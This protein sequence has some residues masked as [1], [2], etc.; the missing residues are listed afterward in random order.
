MRHPPD[1]EPFDVERLDQL[2]REGVELLL[3]DS[4][5]IDASGSAGSEEGVGRALDDI[6][7]DAPQAVVV[8]MFASNVHRLRM[9]GEIAARHG[10]RIVALG[11]GVSTHARV[12]RATPR[13]TGKDA[14][15]PYLDWPVNLGWAEERA[16]DLP[17]RSILAIATGSQGERTAAL[18]RLA[19]GE[20][21]ALDLT[22]EDVVV[23]SSRIIPGNEPEVV[24]V[25]N[26]LLRRGV[27]LRTW[28]S[29]RG[30][31]VSGHAHRQEQRRMIE[32]VRPGA[33][34]PVHGTLHHLSQ[35]AKL[36][37]EIGVS[38]VSVL[39]NGDVGTL[40]DSGLRKSGRVQ[41]G[42]V[43][44]FGGR[45]LP[46]QVIAERAALASVGAVH[47]AVPL[48]TRGR[49]AGEIA[50]AT[51]GVIDEA[52]HPDL[53]PAARR[54]ARAALEELLGLPGP[55][56]DDER[57]AETARLAVRRTLAKA[58]GFKPVTHA[59]LVR[60]SP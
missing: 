13:S 10:R 50:I 59:A 18:A 40:D 28:W 43:S 16:R 30:V 25:M 11:R 47:V 51:R 17:K 56:P 1:G 5:N 19:R 57:I 8:S 23:M 35:H 20:H 3:S 58:L 55:R 15:R 27:E 21:P 12:A 45:V 42:R 33:F 60:I 52:D 6:V 41:A 44:V 53:V 31:H 46:A 37:S 9:L 48:D 32:L 38:K 39:E 26:D 22:E 49:L 14:G 29:D 2:S 34:V 36:A 7:G 4:T 54:N 24:R